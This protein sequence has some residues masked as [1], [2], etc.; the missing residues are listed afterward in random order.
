[1][2]S[3]ILRQFESRASLWERQR[4]AVLHSLLDA[5]RDSLQ[6]RDDDNRYQ[7]IRQAGL[8]TT[9]PV[10]LAASPIIGFLIGRFIDRKLGTEPVFSAVFVIL[11]FVAGAIQVTR[12]VRLA[13]KT[14]EDKK[15]DSGR[16]T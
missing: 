16:G 9:I 11:G 8:L 14:R 7:A 4:T 12:I 5:V 1:M 2:I 10:L 6:K 13:N 3:F 15:K